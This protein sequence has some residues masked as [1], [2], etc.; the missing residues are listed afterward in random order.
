MKKLIIACCSIIL[1]SNVSAQIK[2]PGFELKSD[3]LNSLPANWI[4]KKA[5]GFTTS[6]D[7]NIKFA[8]QGH[9]V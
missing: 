2:N 1:Y 5:D 9:L 4:I 6:L 3:S 8:V 7:E